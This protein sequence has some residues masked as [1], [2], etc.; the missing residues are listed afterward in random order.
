MDR[1]DRA[2]K[3]SRLSKG[4]SEFEHLPTP[5]LSIGFFWVN[6]KK[7]QPPH[8]GE[9][10]RQPIDLTIPSPLVE[11]HILPDSFPKLVQ[12]VGPQLGSSFFGSI[13]LA[14]SSK[15]GNPIFPLKV[16]FFYPEKME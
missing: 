2:G 8:W 7:V 12:K 9:P 6:Q 16:V 14:H 3:A 13:F 4:A 11:V 1:A 10:W 5:Y 15:V